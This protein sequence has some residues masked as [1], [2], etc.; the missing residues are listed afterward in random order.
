MIIMIC[1]LCQ[2]ATSINRMHYF[3]DV[4]STCGK[5]WSFERV[6]G[7]DFHD[8]ADLEIPG[9]PRR[10]DCE[11]LCMRNVPPCRS[12]TYD[13]FRRLCRLYSEDRRSK[14]SAFIRDL[15]EM[16]YLENQCASG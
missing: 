15:P 11:E 7:Y 4:G 5:L 10:T 16:E 3:C 6:P 8:I 9:V 12:A 1:F 2:Y 13:A 14:P